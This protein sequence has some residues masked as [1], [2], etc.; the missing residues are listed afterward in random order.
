MIVLML[1]NKETGQYWRRGCRWTTQDRAEVWHTLNGPSQALN[2]IRLRQKYLNKPVPETE[3]VSF[4]LVEI[5]LT[6]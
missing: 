5:D 3:I 2:R 1:R 6:S 4:E